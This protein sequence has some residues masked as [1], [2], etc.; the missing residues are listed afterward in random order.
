MKRLVKYGLIVFVGSLL[1]IIS[2]YYFLNIIFKLEIKERLTLSLSFAAIFAT[3]GGAYLGA[4]VSSDN[5][6]KLNKSQMIME[7]LKEN[8]TTNKDLINKFKKL[9]IIT[10][11]NLIHNVRNINQLN[12]STTKLKDLEKKL[13]T[14][15]DASTKVSHSVYYPI[16]RLRITIKDSIRSYNNIEGK[17]NKQFKRSISKQ[18]KKTYNIDTD[19]ELINLVEFDDLKAINNEKLELVRCEVEI[20]KDKEKV[21]KKLQSVESK[22]NEGKTDVHN[23][24]NKKIH[25]SSEEINNLDDNERKKYLDSLKKSKIHH[26][27]LKSNN[28]IENSLNKI[29]VDFEKRDIINKSIKETKVYDIKCSKL[30]SDVKYLKKNNS[31]LKNIT[32]KIQKKYEEIY[33]KDENDLDNFIMKYYRF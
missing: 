32:N 9:N 30:L 3:F 4:K 29:K 2:S 21:Q 19:D 20:V 10:R 1:L 11:I 14:I 13:E 33:F 16:E 17:M 27:L 15:L 8:S 28:S 26:L 22:Y 23:N 5:A 18:L 25:I 6:V 24:E 7:D 31:K 12:N